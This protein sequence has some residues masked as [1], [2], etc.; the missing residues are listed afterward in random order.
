MEPQRSWL[1]H[2]I[3]EKET[4]IY[5]LIL[6][7]TTIETEGGSIE[8]PEKHYGTSRKKIVTNDF[9]RAANKRIVHNLYM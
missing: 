2:Q 5:E 4:A 9:D 8:S 1:C 7:L 3:T 6:S